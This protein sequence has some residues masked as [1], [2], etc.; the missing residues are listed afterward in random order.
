MLPKVS[1]IMNCHNGEKYL[2]K[3]YQCDKP[4]LQKLGINIWDNKST[5]R[6]EKIFKDFKD[7]RLRY[8]RSNN[9]L[10]L[11]KARN[12]AIKKCRGKFIAFL[13]TD[14]CTKKDSKTR[15]ILEKNQSIPLIY[16][17]W[18]YLIK[19]KI[20]KKFLIIRNFHQ[21]KFYKVY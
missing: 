15:N 14:D 13:D 12:N 4:N 3:V 18:I 11:Y 21:E 6:S 8:F 5:D 19:K 9:Y 20:K 7:K 2:K 1:I 10:K 16:S 17:N